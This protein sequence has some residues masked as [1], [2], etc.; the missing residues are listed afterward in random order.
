MAAGLRARGEEAGTTI[1]Y[2]G[3]ADPAY[4]VPRA[5]LFDPARGD[6]PPG[7]YAVSE[8]LRCCGPE[9]TLFH[10]DRA[11]AVGF[12]RLRRALAERGTRLPRDGM[13]Y[14]IVLWELKEKGP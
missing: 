7:R 12:D 8:F 3:G 6:V 9:A 5:T 11:A 2:F 4:Y 14:S 10:R 13:G 1:A